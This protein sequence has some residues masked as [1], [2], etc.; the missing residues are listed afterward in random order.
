MPD[1]THTLSNIVDLTGA[2]P[3]SIQLWA[4][5]G[6]LSPISTSDRRGSGTHRRFRHREAEIAAIVAPLSRMGVSI[7][8]LKR[9]ANEIRKMRLWARRSGDST[10]VEVLE[11]ARRGE[12]ENYLMFSEISG[13][14]PKLEFCSGDEG[15]VSVRL[16][17]RASG[18]LLVNL[19]DVLRP[20][21]EK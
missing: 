7:G 3:R 19:N 11:R 2:K 15:T 17:H 16:P 5:A 12:G 1:L 9:V 4:D 6:V 21:N 13:R 10:S 14:P 20:L 8:H 18:A